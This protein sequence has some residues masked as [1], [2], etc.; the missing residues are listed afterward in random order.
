MRFKNYLSS[1]HLLALAALVLAGPDMAAAQVHG[2]ER[3]PDYNPDRCVMAV[4]MIDAVNRHDV[5]DT[6][7]HSAAADTLFA[8]TVES[9]RACQ[10]VYANRPLPAVERLN[11]AR[12]QRVT[13]QDIAALETERRHLESLA[14]SPAEERA[15]ELSLMLQD[16]LAGMPARLERA[17]ELLGEMVALGPAASGLQVVSRFYVLSAAISHDDLDLMREQMDALREAWTALDQ[18]ERDWRLIWLLTAAYRT[19][20]MDALMTGRD[21]AI[22]TLDRLIGIIPSS[23][24]RV[25][26]RLRSL[27]R[28]YRLMDEEAPS[29]VADF[30]YNTGPIGATRPAPGRVSLVLPL[31]RPCTE[32]NRCSNMVD[33]ARRLDDAFGAEG[34]DITF[35]TRTAGFYADTAPAL[36]QAEAR[37]DSTYFLHDVGIP[38]ALAIA[39]TKFS[40]RPDGRRTNEPTTDDLN[41][42]QARVV[43][44]DRAGIVRYVAED[45]S[46]VLEPRLTALIERLVHERPD[47]GAGGA[48][49]ED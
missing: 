20:E 3:F 47:G 17:V 40:F 16:N 13:G 26:G 35:R 38:G 45:W 23:Q 44:I 49:G 21:A 12:V 4:R 19:A 48:A 8:A 1:P 27:Q 9:I 37:Y 22:E 24:P 6:A 46:P 34:L 33:A 43:V 28:M 41:Y 32:G 29:L 2:P 31:R 42:L 14:G 5:R 15:W 10:R 30:W 36:P 11:A 39:E 7:M 25:H 18:Q